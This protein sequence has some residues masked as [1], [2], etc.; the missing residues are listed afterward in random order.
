MDKILHR[1]TSKNR[2]LKAARSLAG[3]EEMLFWLVMEKRAV[4]QR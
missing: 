1:G 2:F 3:F 4:V